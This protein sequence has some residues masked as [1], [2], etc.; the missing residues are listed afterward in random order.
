MITG[1]HNR[2]PVVA[3]PTPGT[4]PGGR[5]A[6]GQCGVAHGEL[7]P[8]SPGDTVGELAPDARM[9]AGPRRCSLP[10]AGGARRGGSGLRGR[11]RRGLR[12]VTKQGEGELGLERLKD[13]SQ[14]VEDTTASHLRGGI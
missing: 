14:T 13:E 5:R 9:V 1:S 4:A 8:Q 6:R 11:L 10:V 12:T 7:A 2:W 3:R